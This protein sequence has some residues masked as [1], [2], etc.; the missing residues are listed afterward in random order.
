MAQAR[1]FSSTAQPTT[2][3][4]SI[5]NTNTSIPLAATT[6]F[7][8]QFPYTLALDYGN[9]LEELVDVSSV[10]GLNANVTRAVDGTTAAS[11]SAGA[12]VRHV[13]SA[14]DFNAFY[15]HLGST[16][17]V[18]GI[19]GNVV[20]DTDTQ[21]LTNKTLASPTITG[22]VSGTP[23]YTGGTMT[24]TWNTNVTFQAN[25]LGN[26]P[27]TVKGFPASTAN[28][29]VVQNSSAF[30]YFQVNNNGT[31]SFTP[32]SSG[33]V[34]LVVAANT[35]Q[36][37]DLADFNVN[38]VVQAAVTSNGTLFSTS[39]AI[40]GSA[41][42]S[43]LWAVNSTGSQ[44]QIF[45]S[46]GI[47]A[48]TTKVTGDTNIRWQ[49]T[50]DGQINWGP[51][52]AATDTQLVRT[53][54]NTLTTGN[55]V[56]NGNLTVNGVGQRIFVLKTV[57]E[58]ASNTANVHSDATLFAT[59]SPGTYVFEGYI[60]Y[61]TPSGANFQMGFNYSGTFGTNNWVPTG[62]GGG[63]ST[64]T[65]ALRMA[66]VAVSSTV[67]NAGAIFLNSG[68]YSGTQVVRPRGVIVVTGT[69]TLQFYWGPNTSNATNTTVGAGSYLLI[70]RVA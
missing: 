53:A 56:L 24:G 5:S 66:S 6:G 18:H 21:T 32:N 45:S 43:P 60:F 47:T 55:L 22:T 41:V 64:D 40:V 52:N 11:H 4:A 51:G 36:T 29:F 44:S 61:G 25:A 14:R 28:L 17:G 33:V 8:V 68:T 58:N 7:P 69:G 39:G 50:S 38:S 2:L 59:L 31:S 19:T 49:V 57:S 48:L 30:T 70:D 63:G 35:G 12:P 23:T 13:S 9:S 3:T 46:T 67:S 34:P 54:A 16:S 26:I 20:G 65:Q 37:G 10:A 1:F 62:I 42:G 15:V 27:F